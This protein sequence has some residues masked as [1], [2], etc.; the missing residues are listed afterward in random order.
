MFFRDYYSYN[1]HTIEIH[2]EMSVKLLI[3]VTV[4][5]PE[6]AQYDCSLLMGILNIL[7]IWKDC[8][9]SD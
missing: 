2:N 1:I 7:A 8:I 5:D 4:L 3:D 9:W 6:H